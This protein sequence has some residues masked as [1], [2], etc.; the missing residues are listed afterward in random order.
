MSRL[1]IAIAGAALLV[2]TSAY[3]QSASIGSVTTSAD[4]TIVPGTPCFECTSG[5]ITF[6]THVGP[7]A[8]SASFPSATIPATANGK[9]LWNSYVTEDPKS[10]TIEFLS[11]NGLTGTPIGVTSTSTVTVGVNNG[12][13][14]N[15]HSTITPAAFGFYVA[16][17]GDGTCLLTG[18]CSQVAPTT[19]YDFED[20][21]AIS[22]GSFAGVGFDFSVTASAYG[23]DDNVL[24]HVVGSLELA[25]DGS[26][27]I[28]QNILD[29]QGKLVGF[30]LETP[31]AG[32]AIPYHSLGYNWLETP[33]DVA[34]LFETEYQTLTYQTTVYSYMNSGCL[35][36]RGG[37]DA[38]VTACLVAYSGFGDPIGRGVSEF[39]TASM[40]SA[41]FDPQ[42]HGDGDLIDGLH[43]SPFT[44]ST[45]TIRGGTL[46]VGGSNAG[47]PE[48][49]TWAMM[50][51]GFGAIGAMARRRRAVG[52]TI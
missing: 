7:G 49:A 25:V 9:A 22:D 29:A 41:D 2:G 32:G 40:M 18:S 44:I 46:F 36:G 11:A 20:F 33:I 26:L 39:S 1:G 28:N 16:S 15:V 3:A 37:V 6:P 34:G 24:Y 23:F 13:G 10:G 43:F 50:I 48:P 17:V 52:A 38:G 35:S 8:G 12:G 19:S 47:V 21:A 42:N 5:G 45:P 4:T 51:A 27:I 14:L 31:P 30:Q